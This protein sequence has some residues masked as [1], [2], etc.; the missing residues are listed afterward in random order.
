MKSEWQRILW[1]SKIGIT[2]RMTK[3]SR[4]FFYTGKKSLTININ[5]SQ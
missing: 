3:F 1:N 4:R 5:F 2:K